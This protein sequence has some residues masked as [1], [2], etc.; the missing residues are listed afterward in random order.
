MKILTSVPREI[1]FHKDRQPIRAAL[2]G[3][4]WRRRRMT[5]K[6]QPATAPAT[7]A[8]VETLVERA[9][10]Q[11]RQLNASEESSRLFPDGLE[12]LDVDLDTGNGAR[13]SLK[14]KGRQ[15]DSAAST[16]V[17]GGADENDVR[18]M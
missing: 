7:Q 11:I 13:V 9:F 3:E 4:E 12:S 15:A 16:T 10:E 5:P 8:T 6:R 17:S 2:E 1:R 18:I 14:L